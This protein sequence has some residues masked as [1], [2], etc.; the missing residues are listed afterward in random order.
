MIKGSSALKEKIEIMTEKV[1]KS[2]KG[3]GPLA[4]ISIENNINPAVLDLA[5]QDGL[6]GKDGDE[7]TKDIL[8]K[9]ARTINLNPEESFVKG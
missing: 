1:R 9:A 3:E 4:K 7:T 6:P 2:G 5:I 8:R